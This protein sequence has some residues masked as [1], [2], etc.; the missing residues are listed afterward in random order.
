[1][2]IQGTPLWIVFLISLAIIF[3][4]I[5]VGYQ[6]GHRLRSRVGGKE[7]V[8]KSLLA[9]ACLGLLSFTLAIVFGIAQGHYTTQVQL[10]TDEANA[11]S[12][13]SSKADLLP[14]PDRTEVRDLLREYANLR[15]QPRQPAPI[16][17][18]GTGES[19]SKE[20]LA[21]L[22]RRVAEVIA[23]QPTVVATQLVNS[24]TE[25][26]RIRNNR[27]LI[28]EHRNLPGF[29]WLALYGLAVVA[30]SVGGFYSGLSG[31]HRF[32]P[33]TLSL[34]IAYSA[35]FTMIA[36]LDGSSGRIQRFT[37]QVFGA[38]F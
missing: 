10:V 22:W 13:A 16:L 26:I 30:M 23:E 7:L 38:L 4:S 3:C 20:I 1:M 9:T 29:L 8:G 17:Q 19:E 15:R 25:L 24:V 32:V 33:V 28:G 5:E 18:T 2:L 35:V 27:I 12:L 31:S 14:E 11:V 21:V 36:E 6:V 34:S 37:E